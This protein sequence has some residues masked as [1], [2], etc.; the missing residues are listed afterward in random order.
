MRCKMYMGSKIYGNTKHGAHQTLN[1]MPA[2]LNP[3]P[4]IFFFIFISILFL[5]Q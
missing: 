5:M 2:S 4:T 3:K 1:A